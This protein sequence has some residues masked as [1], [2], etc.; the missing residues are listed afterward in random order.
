[1]SEQNWD[2]VAQE[3]LEAV[4][5]KL[6]KAVR[7][8]SEEIYENVHDAILDNL[9]DNLQFNIKSRIDVAD[10]Q[11]RTDRARADKC[12]LSENILRSALFEIKRFAAPLATQ[13]E[14]NIWRTAELILATANKA[15]AQSEAVY[16][17]NPA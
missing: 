2:D 5:N 8:A 12:T 17:P 7:K 4:E 3:I 16:A 15:I 6:E 10:R 11:A 1:M 13:G 14:D 9:S